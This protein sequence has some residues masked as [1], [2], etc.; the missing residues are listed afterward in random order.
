ML[1]RLPHSVPPHD[2]ESASGYLLRALVRNGASVKEAM[3]AC[4]AARLSRPLASDADLLA[5]LVDVPVEWLEHRM[6]ISRTRDQWSEVKLF[7]HVWRE[8]WL[9]RGGPQ[10]V[11][12]ICLEE[13]G[14]ARLEWDLLPY[15]ACHIHKQP[16]QDVCEGCKRAISPTRP[17]LEVCE[18]GGYLVAEMQRLDDG[19]SPDILRWCSWL[20]Q[21]LLVD[22]DRAGGLQPEDLAPQLQGTS[23]DGAFRL[24]FAYGGGAKAYRGT[25][26][27]SK[28]AW[29]R[30]ERVQQLLSAGLT[31]LQAAAR[32][33]HRGLP[34]S[35]AYAVAE[36]VVAGITTND[37]AA[38][39]R[40]MT[41]LKLGRRWRNAVPR[42]PAQQDLFQDPSG[43]ES[44]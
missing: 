4:R 23:L 8:P 40:E 21:G 38:A 43:V 42:C 26:I 9:L 12:P 34:A 18:C 24:V 36:Q 11:C 17:S 27:Q 15:C 33:D 25:Q 30:T 28:A 37:R 19:V 3:S 1:T 16:L 13:T 39:A 22:D 35:T 31:A 6:P 5:E 2:I 14:V 20:S 32:R 44:A 10:Q 41:R 29:L 7:G